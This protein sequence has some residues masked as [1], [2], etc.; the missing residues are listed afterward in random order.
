MYDATNGINYSSY[1]STLLP[2]NPADNFLCGNQNFANFD[3]PLYFM[4]NMRSSFSSSSSSGFD[5]L[6][7]DG[8]A[9]AQDEQLVGI[10]VEKKLVSGHLSQLLRVKQYKEVK[11]LKRPDEGH[12][13][14]V[15]QMKVLLFF[16]KSS[17]V[18]ALLLYVRVLL[19][20]FSFPPLGLGSGDR[21]MFYQF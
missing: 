9:A 4:P 6:T 14:R 8:D 16:M 7:D 11:A 21:Y 20:N 13:E 15:V 17:A 5:G 18:R 1:F 12:C 2:V 19:L 3:D 10:V